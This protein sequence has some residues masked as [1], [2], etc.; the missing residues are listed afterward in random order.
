MSSSPSSTE[1]SRSPLHELY[2][3]RVPWQRL[4]SFP[5]PAPGPDRERGDA[6]VAALA[7]LLR[8]RV[9]PE[10]VERTGRLP[11]G[12]MAALREGGFL[13]LTTG[14][15]LG[16]LGLTPYHAF[17]VLE[18]AASRCTPVAFS[19]AITNGFGSGSYLPLLPEGPLK[20]LIAERVREGI[21]SA[22]AD[23]EAI[24]TANERR[25]TT[26]VPVDD[27]KFYEITGEKVF[28]GNGTVADLMDVSA[29]V[30][31]PDGREEVRLL[32]VDSRTDGFE[33]LDRHEFMGLRG[34][35][36]GRLRLDRV[37]V[38]AFH[39]LDESEES[40]RMRP[41]ERGAGPGA[42]AGTG[43]GVEA[44]AGAEPGFVPTDFG[45]LAALG[46]IL[47]IGPASL[48]LARLCL[49]WSREFV[50]GRVI[51]GRGLGEYEEIR[52]RIAETAAD[53]YTVDTVMTWVL[54]AHRSGDNQPELTAAKNLTSLACW[55][56]V[57][58]T[59]SL[60]GGEG[61]ET[62]AS[63]AG[64]GA[65]PFPV[66]RAFRDARALRVA[67]GVDFM[68][69][70]WSAEAALSTCWLTGDPPDITLLDGVPAPD[71]AGLSPAGRE[72]LA[73]LHRQ[74][75]E[76][77]ATCARLSVGRPAE[78]VFRQQRHTTVLGRIGTELLGMALVLAR[79]AARA[80][81][82]DPAELPLADLAC[83]TARL[84]LAALWPRLAEPD[85]AEPAFVAPAAAWLDG[86]GLDFLV[87]DV[88][89]DLPYTASPGKDAR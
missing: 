3:G 73:F 59:V 64:R 2:S 8:E 69:D 56:T 40:W 51:D 63:K 9:D 57:D 34:A 24:G 44:E 23:A 78:E 74:A 54:H 81:R 42:E 82:G 21:V 83:A 53:V 25:A 45:Q 89:T 55:R 79:A 77:A 67:G 7:R 31:E 33:A 68:V 32:F 66:E 19:L 10:E 87:R 58:R 5:E 86:T 52:R 71:G 70:R 6:A 12:L 46:R 72:H 75:Q 22:G 88:V 20:E 80:R 35:E 16:G 60:L 26:A 36:I 29:T 38:P 18:V 27:G 76:L 4:T 65:Q 30:R 62:A 1:P 49:H 37:R 11:E 41:A 47:V 85:T 50:R 14:P 17:R 28:I 39:L 84:R 43:A 61:Y 15:E 13:K 48:A